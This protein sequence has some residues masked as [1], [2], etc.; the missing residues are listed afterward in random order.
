ME[1]KELL[2]LINKRRIEVTKEQKLHQ[3]RHD[4]IM[5]R[6][7]PNCGEKLTMKP[8]IRKTWFMI[9]NLGDLYSC[10]CGFEHKEI[11]LDY[12]LGPI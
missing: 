12:D 8:Y 4:A 2:E 11:Y 10:I 5:L 9:H 6:I 1:E 7:C 3:I